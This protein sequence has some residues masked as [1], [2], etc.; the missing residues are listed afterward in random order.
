M[1]YPPMKPRSFLFL[2]SLLAL[3][4]WSGL[5]FWTSNATAADPP[6]FEEDMLLGNDKLAVLPVNDL[7]MHCM[8]KEYSVFT[9]LP[10]FNVI[11]TQVV[12]RN[13][14][15]PPQLLNGSQVEVRYMGTTD[16]DGSINTTS[17]TKTDF[18][19]HADALFGVTL[20]DGE[21]LTGLYMPA[22]APIP[23]PQPT[24]YDPT[25][26]SFGAFG[27]PI[28]PL[29]DSAVYNP[30]PLLRFGVYRAGSDRLLA[31]TDAVVPVSSEVDCKLC[32]VGNEIGTTRA[33]V[34]W[35]ASPD[36]EVEAKQNVLIL[37]D[38]DHGTTLMA[39]QP[40]LCA[41]CHY[42]PALD[43]AG[44]GP[45]GAQIGTSLMSEAMHE[46]HGNLVDAGGFPV[47]PPQGT[48]EQTCFQCHPG[49]E[50]QCQRGAMKNGGMQCL[51]CHGDMLSVGGAY[52]LLAGGS[53]DGTN[54]GGSRRPW[55]DLPRCQSCHTGD[56]LLHRSGPDVTLAADGIRLRKAY[57]NQ[58][59]S[60]SPLLAVNDRFAEEPN[61]LY[62]FS[63]GH[64][65]IS[66]EAC[67][68]AT[69]AVWPNANRRSADNATSFELQGHEGMLMECST[70][71]QEGT[72]PSKTMDGPHG[73]HQVG[74]TTFARTEDHKEL[75]EQNEA[76]CQSCHGI[77]LRGTVLSR[78]GDTRSLEKKDH[79]RITLT[80]GQIVSCDLCHELPDPD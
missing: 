41:A 73:M 19:D 28:T 60:A 39:S 3:A 63:R 22:D 77:D 51:D 5:H 64:G 13:P 21:S 4:S 49:F 7:G 11:N 52:P 69:H 79:G 18:W 80:K 42:S 16:L 20:Q 14:F 55:T 58:D 37:H 12:Y 27:V 75:W 74:D 57:R 8:D 23:G 68:G 33:G 71:H 50:T 78:M 34:T 46:Y 10:P 2:G 47:F 15:G 53:I 54:D 29:D 56:A 67:H 61:T 31:W 45:T 66:C 72:L 1:V 35:S 17:V 44:T 25:T 76:L 9:I 62:R 30:Y 65:G 6:L 70:C 38:V 26:E 43:L 59:L 36:P 48:V 40:V 32:H 24:A